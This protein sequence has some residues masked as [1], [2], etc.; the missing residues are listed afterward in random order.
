MPMRS[1]SA[2]LVSIEV[3]FGPRSFTCR[4]FTSRVAALEN[5]NRGSC[6]AGSSGATFAATSALR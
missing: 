2:S 4:E 3:S 6:R 5:E 1:M